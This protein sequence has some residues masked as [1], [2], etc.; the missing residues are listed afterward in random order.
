MNNKSRK[1][2]SEA[3]CYLCNAKM[4]IPKENWEN[5]I[6]QKGWELIYAGDENGN[7]KEVEICSTC[8]EKFIEKRIKCSSC[9]ETICTPTRSKITYLENS[10]W[11]IFVEDETKIIRTCCPKCFNLIEKICMKAITKTSGHKC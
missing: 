2:M 9:D 5:Y 6:K 11:V 4:K 10:K 1:M 3:S 7:E 8:V